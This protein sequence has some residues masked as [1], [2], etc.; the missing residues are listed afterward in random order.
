MSYELSA[1]EWEIHPR[2]VKKALSE[3]NQVFSSE[4][5]NNEN[6]SQNEDRQ[7][8]YVVLERFKNLFIKEFY[9]VR[10]SILE[11]KIED[12][13]HVFARYV[14]TNY[15]GLLV[16]KNRLPNAPPEK[17]KSRKYKN[18]VSFQEATKL[19][20]DQLQTLFVHPLMYLMESECKNEL[21]VAH[22]METPTE[23]FLNAISSNKVGII[24]HN[25][26]VAEE[27]KPIYSTQ[28][29][30][31]FTL[32]Y[33]GHSI[34]ARYN[35]YLQGVFLEFQSFVEST[36]ENSPGYMNKMRFLNR[37]KEKIS[38]VQRFYYKTPESSDCNFSLFKYSRKD[39][40]DNLRLRLYDHKIL[41]D[42]QLF[43]KA[44]TPLT[45]VQKIY[46]MRSLQFVKS[47][48]NLVKIC[49]KELDNLDPQNQEKLNQLA[50]RFDNGP[51]PAE[52]LQWRGNIN[53]LITFFYD[54]STQILIGGKPILNATKKQIVRL[55]T[56]NFLQKDGDPINA[57][58]INTIF[59]PSKELKRPPLYKRIIIPT[60]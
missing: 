8:L 14:E 3:L 20:N 17:K 10:T 56:R 18:N 42:F 33:N 49:R 25:S 44:L 4:N 7:T 23:I 31:L 51:E 59:T 60:V 46:I 48:L 55:L 40:C 19:I 12:A 57:T 53:Q 24:L 2:Q 6:Q 11:H 41:K 45:E 26:Y 5:T 29:N 16:L 52:K 50:L 36:L 9:R 21:I 35:E 1:I 38:S 28:V 39:A 47:Q 34:E 54:A 27:Y 22:L 13:E 58:T 15:E 32:E 43:Q 37:L 30:K